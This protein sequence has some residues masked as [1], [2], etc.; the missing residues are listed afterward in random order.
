MQ[1]A[2]A[3]GGGVLP[4]RWISWQAWIRYTDACRKHFIANRRNFGRAGASN[5]RPELIRAGFDLALYAVLSGS[6]LKGVVE[7]AGMQLAMGGSMLEER[8]SSMEMDM[9]R[10]I[11]VLEQWEDELWLELRAL[12]T[13]EIR[14]LFEPLISQSEHAETAALTP[15]TIAQAV[16]TVEESVKCYAS[17]DVEAGS[18]GPVLGSIQRYII[19]LDLPGLVDYL[20]EQCSCAARQMAAGDERGEQGLGIYAHVCISLKVAI[21]LH[22]GQALLDRKKGEM[23]APGSHLDSD[24]DRW[25]KMMTGL[26]E[27]MDHVCQAYLDAQIER[28]EWDDVP[29]TLRLMMND[30]VGDKQQGRSVLA[31]AFNGVLAK[32]HDDNRAR[33]QAL[34]VKY[35]QAIEMKESDALE[36][37]KRMDLLQIWLG[38]E[39]FQGVGNEV[40]AKLGDSSG[41]IDIDVGERLQE[42]FQP[43]YGQWHVGVSQAHTFLRTFCS[44]RQ[45]RKVSDVAARLLLLLQSTAQD[46]SDSYGAFQ[47][48]GLLPPRPG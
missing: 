40:V 34:S 27:G 41:T 16:D 13:A 15:L 10:N 33:V 38:P 23:L 29:V 26:L 5:D 25:E 17:T 21:F 39:F 31:D 20:Q 3:V 7:E 4:D 18:L 9:L 6:K 2:S 12:F 37:R 35:L 47:S 22:G 48:R 11:G 42:L 19:A 36:R 44:Q 30:Q 1:C 32:M 46:S 28:C 43:G 14:R 45:E 24:G 8:A